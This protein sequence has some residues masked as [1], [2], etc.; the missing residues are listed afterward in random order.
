MWYRCGAL[1]I[2]GTPGCHRRFALQV[3][4][5]LNAGDLRPPHVPFELLQQL[6]QSRPVLADL[7]A[8][9]TGADDEFDA[10]SIPRPEMVWTARLS[11]S[12][13]RVKGMAASSSAPVAQLPGVIDDRLARHVFDKSHAEAD[14]TTTL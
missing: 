10:G 1:L 9:L 4:E 8:T 13:A 2:E 14:L 7:Q 11:A 3:T 12:A 5:A 6:A